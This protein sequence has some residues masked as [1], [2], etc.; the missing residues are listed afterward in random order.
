[1]SSSLEN[2]PRVLIACEFSGIVRNEFLRIGFDAWSCD[3]LPSERPGPHIQGDVLGVLNDGWDL[4]IAHPPC[5]Y[6]S[7]AG[8][9]WKDQPGRSLKIDLAIEFFRKLLD[10]P[11][12]YI[13]IENPK[14]YAIARIRK[15]DQIVQPY[16]FGDPFEKKICLWLK[17]LPPLM[18]SLICADFER[19]WTTRKS[20]SHRA[21][22]RSRTFPG[23]ARQMA[24]Q[25][26]RALGTPLP[27]RGVPTMIYGE[28]RW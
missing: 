21:A 15:P 5:Q 19:N 12:P 24:K 16:H 13:A 27:N 2:A 7:Y 8:L 9:R 18:A 23:M 1:M 22:D 3:L 10:A 17:N 14:G 4:M 11:I 20:G 25:W 26:G 6:L 28:N